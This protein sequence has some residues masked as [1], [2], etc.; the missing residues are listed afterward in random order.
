MGTFFHNR[1][2][3]IETCKLQLTQNSPPTECFLRPLW[4]IYYQILVNI[5]IE[6]IFSAI[7]QKN[8]HMDNL[9]FQTDNK[10]YPSHDCRS[11]ESI[12]HHFL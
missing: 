6:I 3:T 9:V 11:K 1:I 5:F 2:T 10:A 8:P 4:G 7:Y 12:F